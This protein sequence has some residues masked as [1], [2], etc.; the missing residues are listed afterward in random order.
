MIKA[1]RDVGM[2][3][4]WF[5]QNP[6]V[7]GQ[8]QNNSTA[9]HWVVM[10]E[11]FNLQVVDV[12]HQNIIGYLG[13]N[14]TYD[15]FLSGACS[16]CETGRFNKQFFDPILAAVKGTYPLYNSYSIQAECSPWMACQ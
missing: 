16:T 7:P 4:T 11:A 6:T 3:S 1:L 8:N 13:Y 9:E 14:T 5:N 12:A 10:P 2:N 15:N